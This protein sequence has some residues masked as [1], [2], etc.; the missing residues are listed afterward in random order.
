[1]LPNKNRLNY[2]FGLV[3]E[4]NWAKSYIVFHFKIPFLAHF[5]I[6][7]K[8]HLGKNQGILIKTRV[9]NNIWIFLFLN[10]LF[11]DGEI[12]RGI[13]QVSTYIFEIS[14]LFL[15]KQFFSKM[16]QQICSDRHGMRTKKILFS[17]SRLSNCIRIFWHFFSL[18]F[19]EE[20]E[21]NINSE[22]VQFSTN[23]LFQDRWWQ[24]RKFFT[25][26]FCNLEDGR[27]WK[28]MR[29]RSLIV[30]FIE[31]RSLSRQET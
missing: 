1:M 14:T 18:L 22:A 15:A 4:S 12:L 25:L 17:V 7:N 13:V 19:L 16:S 23:H 27:S 9:K 6:I 3:G 8:T 24:I 20:E 2:L 28:V 5:S 26:V 10:P 30:Y 31:S 29:F 11:S 21:K